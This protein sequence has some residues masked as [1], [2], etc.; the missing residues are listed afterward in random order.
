MSTAADV[1]D[2][3]HTAIAGIEEDLGFAEDDTSQI[4]KHLLDHE[5][6]EKQVGYLRGDL[7]D[8]TKVT[9]AIGVEVLEQDDPFSLFPD[10][11][12]NMAV[13]RV[14]EITIGFYYGVGVDGAGVRTMIEH[15]SR[16]TNAIRGLGSRLNGTVSRT[17]SFRQSRPKL[18]R[19]HGLDQTHCLYADITMQAEE[20]GATYPA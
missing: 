19:V 13:S 2:A 3:I 18:L 4:Y 9:R 6:V 15:M 7:A 12:G 20:T 16:V 5:L 10:S 17:V 1:R 11:A 14:Y 8:G